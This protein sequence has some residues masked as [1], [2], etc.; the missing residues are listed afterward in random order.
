MK[1][2][3]KQLTE[4]FLAENNIDLMQQYEIT[5]IPA[6]ELIQYNRFDLMAKWIYIDA[7]EK[8]I[9]SDWGVKVYYDNINSF[10]C[11]LFFEPG[12]A[13]KNSFDAYIKDFNKLIDNIKISGFDKEVS[14]IPIGKDNVL[15]DGSH[16]VAVAAYFNQDVTVIKFPELNR[17]YDYQYFRKYMMSDVNMGYMAIQYAHL[18]SNCFMACIWPKADVSKIEEAENLIREVGKIV[19]AQE[20]YLTFQGM[21]NFMVQIYGHQAWTGNISNHFD[22]V[23][24]KAEACYAKGQPIRTYLFEAENLDTVLD[25]KRKIRAIFQI[26]N[27]SIHISDDWRETKEMVEMLYNRNSVNFINFSNPYQYEWLYCQ[28]KELKCILQKENRDVNKYIFC[29]NDISITGKLREYGK[30]NIFPTNIDNLSKDEENRSVLYE[31]VIC[32][33]ERYFYFEG[34]KYL[35]GGEKEIDS[36]KDKIRKNN[37]VANIYTSLKIPKQYRFET[38]DKIC[39]YQLRNSIYGQGQWSLKRYREYKCNRWKERILA[40]VKKL[41]LYK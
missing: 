1:L 2:L 15:L 18:K 27:H 13:S 11:G 32:N 28:Q 8:G 5:T 21:C 9:H 24:G 38:I 40:V 7:Y 4:Y 3:F 37:K 29:T 35:L 30:L 33:P 31:E 20:V 14:L 19:Y 16:R 10:S 12:S 36:I 26:E 17:N 6:R 25:V 39:V 22:G 41:G 23:R 34:M